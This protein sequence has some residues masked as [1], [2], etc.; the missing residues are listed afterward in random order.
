GLTPT[1][2]TRLQAGL[3]TGYLMGGDR[4]RA[5]AALAKALESFATISKPAAVEA[6][7][8]K[9]IHDSD[10]TPNAGLPDNS[11]LHSA[12]VGALQLARL[13]AA[14]DQ[15]EP[16]WQ[17]LLQAWDFTAGIAPNLAPVSSLVN[18]FDK[19][20]SRAKGK[21]YRQLNLRTDDQRFR[22]VNQYRGQLRVYETA[23][24]DRFHLERSL[25]RNAESMGYAEEVA[26]FRDNPGSVVASA[27]GQ[28]Y[29]QAHEDD[30]LLAAFAQ[31]QKLFDEEKYRE[32]AGVLADFRQNRPNEERRDLRAMQLGCRL[33]KLKKVD[34]LLGYA[35]ALKDRSLT[36][37]TLELT[38]ALSV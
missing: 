15:Q 9:Q 20:P 8:M 27:A 3:A 12:A 31:A 1:G 30:R 35:E 5:E 24:K 37:D 26:T 17:T 7:T 22:A 4:S 2:Q 23:S 14:L 21:L 38:S 13:Q 33:L 25:L 36:E 29:Q 18:E 34:A 16:G 11:P 10:G 32:A 6:P 19:Q 28:P